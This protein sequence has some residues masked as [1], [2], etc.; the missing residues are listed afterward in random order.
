[1]TRFASQFVDLAWDA[2]TRP[3]FE[4]KH[5]VIVGTVVLGAAAALLAGFPI[6]STAVAALAAY[7]ILRLGV[8]MLGGLARPVPDP[9]PPGELRKVKLTYRCDVCGA[10]ARMTVAPTE[11][12]EPPRHCQDDMRLVTPVDDL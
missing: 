11:E 2:M 9:P 12:P 5:P 4:L 3:S 1:M 7:A 6:L 10:E 8:A